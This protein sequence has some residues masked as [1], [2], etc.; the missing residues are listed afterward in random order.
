[1]CK[2]SVRLDCVFFPAASVSTENF[3]VATLDEGVRKVISVKVEKHPRTQLRQIPVL[4]F[5]L[6]SL[7]M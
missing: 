3:K 4:W 1:M 5:K 6:D 7:V 2:K